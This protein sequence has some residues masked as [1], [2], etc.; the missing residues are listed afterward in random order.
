MTSSAVIKDNPARSQA[1]LAYWLLAERIIRLEL[2]PG[3]VLLDRDIMEE[4]GIGRTP[5]REAIQRLATEGLTV[6]YPH[7]GVVVSEIS[8]ASTRSI[9][10]FRM[11]ID[12]EA[13]RLASMR[14]SDD[15]A[16]KLTDIAN[17]LANLSSGDNVDRYVGVDR[18]FYAAVGAASRNHYIEETIPRIFNLHLRLWFYISQIRGGWNLLA[19]QHSD[20]AIE[21][22]DAIRLKDPDAANLAVRAYIAQRQKD[23]R[24]LM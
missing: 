16:N 9:Y 20:M 24:S 18:A 21:A 14:R 4:T 8:A 1:E 7:R 2:P 19:K 6:H 3:S 15:E 13:A 11:L 12:G 17:K 22:S 10:E 5:I 23:I